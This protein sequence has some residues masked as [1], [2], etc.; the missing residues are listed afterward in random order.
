MKKI[1]VLLLVLG[2]ANLSQAQKMK[3]KKGIVYVDDQAC[4]KYDGSDLNNVVIT[5]MDETQTIYLK[6]I[7]TG[8]GQN[9][10][11]YTKIVFVEQ[12]KSF[13]SKSYIFT[14]K[15]LVKK[16]IKDKVFEDCKVNTE[17]IDKFILR[18]D[19]KHEEKLIRF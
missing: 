3:F 12:E 10:G 5:D 2:F 15:L 1:L 14:K 18:Y 8:V 11:L 13:T 4:L 17:K 6:F 19:E 7:R 9:G 16:L